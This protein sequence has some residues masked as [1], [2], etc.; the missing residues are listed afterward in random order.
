MNPFASPSTFSL[1]SGAHCFSMLHK[2]RASDSGLHTVS[3]ICAVSES[4]MHLLLC[5]CVYTHIHQQPSF[6][7]KTRQTETPGTVSR[8]TLPDSQGDGVEGQ[9]VAKGRQPCRG[10]SY[11]GVLVFLSCGRS[12][13]RGLVCTWGWDDLVKDPDCHAEEVGLSCGKL[14]VVSNS[15]VWYR[16]LF[17]S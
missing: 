5:T 16:G 2:L 13:E 17:A 3:T 6:L 8:E 1:G 4:G 7:P 15:R 14:P 9:Q 11:T 12:E 10:N